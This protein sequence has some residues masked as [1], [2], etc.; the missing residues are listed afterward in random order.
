MQKI[1]LLGNL[2]K[3]PERRSTKTGVEIF[4]FSL[5]VSIKKDETVWYDCQ[6]WDK[7][8]VLFEKVL[9]F[10]KKGS[11]ILVG[12]SLRKQ[13]IY[14]GKDGSSKIRLAC[15]VDYI[16]FIGGM[17]KKENDNAVSPSF[18]TNKAPSDP[19]F[20]GEPPF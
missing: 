15:D 9:S 4:S 13:E 2:G 14:Q 18:F 7:K 12:G 16:N 8:I 17:Q 10:L 1:T 11:R 5:A 20:Q 6:I 3:D 19:L